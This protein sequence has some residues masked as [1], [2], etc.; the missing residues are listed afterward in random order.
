VRILPDLEGGRSFGL[1]P[2]GLR[3]ELARLSGGRPLST[4]TLH[5]IDGTAL[6]FRAY[7]GFA[8]GFRAP[9]GLEVGAVMGVTRLITTLLRDLTPSHLALVWDTDQPTFRHEMYPEYKANRG[10]PPE[11]MEPQFDL[12]FRACEAL[13]MRSF[14]IPGYEA[15]DVMATLA[16]RASGA[17]VDCL[18]IT[19]DK[20]VQQ[21]VR[22]GVRVLEPKSRDIYGP[23][24]VERRFGVPA[25]R[26]LDYLALAGDSTDNVP[27]VRGVGPK[28]AQALVAGIGD[29]D[30]IY[31]NL[32][33]VEALGIRG[34]K[35]LAV[36]LADQRD[37]AFLS[38]R[39]VAL[40]EAVP[41]SEDSMTFAEL[42]LAPPRPDAD[43]FFDEL[44]FHG[45]LRTMR[46]LIPQEAE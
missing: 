23:E 16:R 46:S 9:S 1:P 32:D 11:D 21:L 33:R 35:S 45:P 36:K 13:G 24:E 4:A 10:A 30:T 43:H 8:Q 29:L 38:R 6:L 2:R 19:P 18:L 25:A 26:L 17:G 34:A 42:R 22:D 27:G 40:D 12:A 31:A 14:R 7:Y 44:G 5:V 39:L 20:D 15:D 3:S 37:E 28:A 41:L